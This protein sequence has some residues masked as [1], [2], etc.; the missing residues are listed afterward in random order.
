[1]N[2]HEAGIVGAR[3]AIAT[4][5]TLALVGCGGGGGD[6]GTPMPVGTLVLDAGNSDTV[7][8]S[9]SAAIFASGPAQSLPVS[10]LAADR[11]TALGKPAMQRAGWIGRVIAFARQPQEAKALAARS[12]RVQPLAVV[13]PFDEPCAVSGT[14]SITFDDRDNDE[15]PS[16]EDVLTLALNACM[17]DASETLNGVAE[18]TYTEITANSVSALMKLTNLSDSTARHSSRMS[19]SMQL[20]YQMVDSNVEI[21]RLTATSAVAV[22]VSTHLPFDDTVTLAAGFVQELTYDAAAFAP[23]STTAGLS[24]LTVSGVLESAAAG[25]TVE[26][27][28]RASAPIKTASGSQYPYAGELVVQGK[29]GTLVLTA[30]SDAVRIELDADDDG[31]PETSDVQDWDWLF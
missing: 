22:G 25:G 10:G 23:G 8:H 9:S 6:G 20:V 5:I 18:V 29:S 3:L 24:T 19:G 27:S 11:S 26:V 2:K 31:T 4:A 12:S 15:V 30:V 21:T 1:M 17:E 28:S 13:G 7:A 14:M 16:A